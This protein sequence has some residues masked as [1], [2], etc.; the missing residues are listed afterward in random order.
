MEE[1]E[2]KMIK[3]IIK[4]LMAI[5]IL[6]SI[7]VLTFLIFNKDEEI[8]EEN[9][10]LNLN[11]DIVSTNPKKSAANFIMQNGTIGDL[12][13][14]KKEDI[15]HLN[16]P[17]SSDMRRSSFDLAKPAIIP[18]SPLIDG[19]EEETIANDLAQFPVY[20]SIENL[21]VDEPAPIYKLPLN[22]NG[23][24]LVE[25]DAVKVNVSFDSIQTTF[26]WPTDFGSDGIIT[27]EVALDSFEEISVTMVNSGGKW[28]IY[29]VEDSEYTLNVRM[30][31][32]SGRGNYD[33]SVE[34]E[35]VEEYIL[36]NVI[37]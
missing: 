1:G 5:G 9:W 13:N 19:N 10:E 34:Q 26:Y 29:D 17:A 8:S 11:S 27:K 23:I 20:Y 6:L 35:V 37:R 28:F 24:G 32:W 7:L 15:V 25:H 21:K 31:T 3:N 2:L 36:E 30:S 33:V 12:T 22:H 16:F 4:G 14:L 18:G